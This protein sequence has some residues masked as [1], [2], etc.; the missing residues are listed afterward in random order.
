MSCR[1]V[2]VGLV[3][4]VV[5]AVTVQLHHLV[6]VFLEKEMFLV[7]SKTMDELFQL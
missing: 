2:V 1:E 3:L 6:Q 5:L 7:C 4:V